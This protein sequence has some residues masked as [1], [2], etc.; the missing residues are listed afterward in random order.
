MADLAAWAPKVR[1]GGTL[2]G[3]DY[4]DGVRKEGVFGVKQAAHEFFGRR[5]EMVT[6][7]YYPS[8]FYTV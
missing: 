6:A 8:W 5:P 7:E 4:M 3:H 2:C 1:K